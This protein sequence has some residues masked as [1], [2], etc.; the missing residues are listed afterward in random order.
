MGFSSRIR[1]QAKID[2]KEV[3]TLYWVYGSTAAG[4]T[5]LTNPPVT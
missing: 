5:N 2:L 1:I 4:D 3:S